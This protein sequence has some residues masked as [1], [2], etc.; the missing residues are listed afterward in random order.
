MYIGAMNLNREKITMQRFYFDF[1]SKD[2]NL[3]DEDGVELDDLAAAYARA[4]RLVYSTMNYLEDPSERWMIHVRNE[5]RSIL[6]TVLSPDC[7][8]TAACRSTH[9]R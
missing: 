6:L 5:R 1:I 7:R 8:R 2:M 9:L 3:P 4:L